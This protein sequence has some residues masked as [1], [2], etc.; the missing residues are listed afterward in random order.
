MAA[1]AL[2]QERPFP[3][4]SNA[5]VMKAVCIRNERPYALENKGLGPVEM[6]IKDC[7]HSNPDSRP[8]FAT[9]IKHLAALGWFK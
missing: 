5:E 2:I 3:N 4:Y 7:W 8:A 9:V 1:E 6:L